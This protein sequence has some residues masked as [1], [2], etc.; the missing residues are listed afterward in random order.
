MISESVI[1]STQD[2]V[3]AL[4]G[5]NEE[6]IGDPVIDYG[7]NNPSWVSFLKDFPSAK[8]YRDRIE[9]FFFFIRSSDV[10]ITD[11][12]SFEEMLLKYFDHLHEA[13]DDDGNPRYKATVFRSFLSMFVAFWKHSG[14]GELKKNL[15]ILEDNI[16]KWEKTTVVLKAKT[17]TVSNCK[18]HHIH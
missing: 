13:T 8:R 5:M 6:V 17:F 12:S 10:T 11:T 14:R 4:L 16:K 2:A 7:Q 15:P 1:L 18:L 9:D 3:S